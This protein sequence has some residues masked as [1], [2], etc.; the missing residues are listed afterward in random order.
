MLLRDLNSYAEFDLSVKIVFV[1]FI[2]LFAKHLFNRIGCAINC[3]ANSVHRKLQ[4]SMKYDMMHETCASLICVDSSLSV[5][6]FVQ[7]NVCLFEIETEPMMGKKE[8]GRK[9]LFHR[10]FVAGNYSSCLFRS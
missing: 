9:F 1:V 3:S 4:L 2:F 6:T 7:C 5:H 10:G 8:R